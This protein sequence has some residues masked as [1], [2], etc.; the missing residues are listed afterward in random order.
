[1]R[2]NTIVKEFKRHSVSVFGEKGSGKDVLMGNVIA[3]RKK[4]YVSNLD[5]GYQR[6]PY[7]YEDIDTGNTYKEILHDKIKP[8]VYPHGEGVDIYLSDCGIYFPSQYCNELN[9]AYPSLPVFFALSRQLAPNASVHTNT[10]ALNR[11]WDKIREQS[12]IYV[13]AVWCKIIFGIVIQKVRIYDKYVS[14][15]NRVRPCRIHKPLVCLSKDRLL[16]IQMYRDNFFNTHGE[17][18]EGIL[19]YR[20]KSHHD[21][22]HFKTYFKGEPKCESDCSSSSPSSQS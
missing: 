16:Q 17:I 18:R 8:Y 3:R 11:V 19:I 5:Y 9:K 7:R 20:N 1:M 4:P 13:Q 22:H 12:T 15:E 2:I 6:I 21:T 14:A 10:Q